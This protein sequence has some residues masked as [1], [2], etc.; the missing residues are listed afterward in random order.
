MTLVMAYLNGN[1]VPNLLRMRT[2]ITKFV[3]TVCAVSAGLPMGPEGPMVHIGACVASVVTYAK[4]C[5]LPALPLMP[6]APVQLSCC[7]DC[8]HSGCRLRMH[9]SLHGNTQ[10]G[11]HHPP[12]TISH[13]AWHY[14][15]TH[16][17]ASYLRHR[18]D[19]SGSGRCL[20]TTPPALAPAGGTCPRPPSRTLIPCNCIIIAMAAALNCPALHTPA[21][22][23][24]TGRRGLL[25]LVLGHNDKLKCK[26]EQIKEK[27]K[28]GCHR[29]YLAVCGFV[30]GWLC[31]LRHVANHESSW[32]AAAGD[33]DGDGDRLAH[34]WNNPGR[35]PACATYHC[36]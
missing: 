16:T 10:R 9:C 35:D 11:H 36:C 4:L 34:M 13:H 17:P 6:N 23:F 26:E 19:T 32:W 31:L 33:G 14:H 2:L 8:M 7:E 25:H 22:A 24:L 30:A 5:K 12:C 29:A 15:T 3:G 18:A 21:A 27:L 1:H 28:V 20:R